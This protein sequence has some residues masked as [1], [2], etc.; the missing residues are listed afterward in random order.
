MSSNAV[1]QES[2]D[3]VWQEDVIEVKVLEDSD[4][5]SIA[6]SPPIDALREGSVATMPFSGSAGAKPE[7]LE[8]DRA[9]AISEYSRLFAKSSDFEDSQVYF[10]RLARLARMA[11]RFEDAVKHA[12]KAV[13]LSGSHYFANKL[14][15]ALLD[16]NQKDMA[17]R[18]L[19][20]LVQEG[21]VSSA[22]RLA[23]LCIQRGDIEGA[24]ENVSIALGANEL[25]WRA[26]MVA[27]A[28]A[29]CEASYERATRFFRVALQDRPR[30]PILY[31][32]LSLAHHWLENSSAALKSA[33]K[34]IALNPF[35][36]QAQLFF[37]DLAIMQSR[38]HPRR[39]ARRY[40]ELF[41]KVES[42][43][44]LIGRLTHLARIS[45]S[46]SDA[47]RILS[48]LKRDQITP[49]IRNNLG[50][51]NADLKKTS[52]ARALFRSAMLG[53][54]EQ[55][56]L[57]NSMLAASNLA[58]N[59]IDGGNYELAEELTTELI[60][61]VPIQECV[62]DKSLSRLLN[63]RLRS[64]YYQRKTRMAESLSQE[65]LNCSN[66]RP[67]VDFTLGTVTVCY[68]TISSGNMRK[69]RRFAELALSASANLE[70]DREYGENAA[71]NNY[72]YVLLELNYLDLARSLVNSIRTDLRDPE[73]CFATKGLYSIKIGK[74]EKGEK[75]YKQAVEA[76]TTSKREPLR[77]ALLKKMNYELGSA[78]VSSDRRRAL[79]YVRSALKI[80]GAAN[81]WPSL[82]LDKKANLLATR[83]R[84]KGSLP[85]T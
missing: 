55:F 33:R 53:E 50:V 42:D 81:L 80:K 59:F 31:L 68:E 21:D 39:L 41:L 2:Y 34:A 73:Y 46:Q 56:D 6:V 60:V 67:S 1:T 69:A 32:N 29:L 7:S 8:S 43:E 54:S 15:V 20:S 79:K 25:D 23:E 14:A 71:L 36:R 45:E 47:I 65:I 83:L 3:L 61:N 77:K 10:H 44:N 13:S 4:S 72:V 19:E 22:L 38:E 40:I 27:G 24:A 12:E 9:Y 18:L 52:R 75:L 70:R 82:V 11:G 5:R 58:N 63:S 35:N 64:L 78:W 26:N 17:E 74:L 66:R 28:V 76:A 84:R 48:S 49:S 30:S 85:S 16:D 37:S 51:L 57:S 62:S